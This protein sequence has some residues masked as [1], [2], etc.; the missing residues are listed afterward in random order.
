MSQ[1]PSGRLN[2]KKPAAKTI[3]TTNI[4]MQAHNTGCSIVASS[5]HSS[6]WLGISLSCLFECCS[7][8]LHLWQRWSS[9]IFRINSIHRNEILDNL[10]ASCYYYKT[11]YIVRMKNDRWNDRRTPI[12]SIVYALIN[13]DE[14]SSTIVKKNIFLL[15][16]KYVR[17]TKENNF[18]YMG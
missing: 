5:L 2:R 11:S 7:G 6:S 17:W 9:C 8:V 13:L 1:W 15:G 3:A 16:F 14:G 4:K 12:I 10:N 18:P